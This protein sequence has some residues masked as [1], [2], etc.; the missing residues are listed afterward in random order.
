[1]QAH[2]AD[3]LA[4]ALSAT[5]IDFPAE[6]IGVER[7]RDAAHGDFAS[8]VA[9]VAAKAAGQKPRDLAQQL[10]DA[11]PASEQVERVEIAGP[12]F[13]NF[14]LAKAATHAVIAQVLEQGVRFGCAPA[15]SGE[16]VM[17]E[18]VSANPNGPLHVGHGRGAALGDSLANVLAA[19]G[20]T[21]SREY[22]VNDAGRQ[23]DI[24]AASVWV[25]YLDRCSVTVPFPAGGYQ[26]EYVRDVAA[27]L[28]AAQGEALCHDAAA[29]TAE[30]PPDAPNGDKD[31]HVDALIARMRALLGEAGYAAVHAAGLDSQLADIR[32]DLEGFGI[33]YDRWFSEAS[34]VSDG[35]IAHALDT[36]KASGHTY[37]QDGA[38]WLAT[39]QMGDDKDRVLLRSNGAHTY[40]AADI[41][42]HLNKLERGFKRLVNVWGADHHGYVARMRAAI[43]SLTGSAE[44]LVVKLSQFVSLYR[45][46]EKVGMSTRA[47][48]FETLR[49]LRT[50]VG[51]DAARYFYVMRNSDQPFDFDLGLATSQS[52]DNPVYY[53]QYAHA[54]VCS[55]F[56]QAAEQGLATDPAAGLDHLARLEAPQETA[57]IT[58]LDRYPEVL[59]SAAEQYAPHVV[60]NYLRE[61]ADR[62]HSL[63]N[64]QRFILP[65]QPE[66]AA[67]R[68]SLAAATRQVVANGLGLLGVTAPE[69]M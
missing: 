20:H 33:T 22:Y 2:I 51:N 21:V 53:I 9:L 29:I 65:D 41:A 61:L 66:L 52:N 60:A 8:N 24:L 34:L 10:V 50:E 13:I 39:S 31:A 32:D 64:A 37:T 35:A 68:L 25:R 69:S 47:G 63:Y 54:R 45:D 30:L 4:Q 17:V 55:V 16:S 5:G 42:Y 14:H 1:M 57:L 28:H 3:L 6:R 48:E 36:L 44:P 23:M 58:Q 7:T 46:G 12:G 49:T 56:A 59:R 27:S 26:G 15:G 19:A 38:L 18:F 11:L 62:F 40:F 67:A 43:E